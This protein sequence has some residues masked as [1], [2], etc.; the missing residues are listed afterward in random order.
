MGEC[1][2]NSLHGPSLLLRTRDPS[3]SLRMTEQDLLAD[4]FGPGFQTLFYLRHELVGYCAV[5]EAVVVA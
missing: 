1:R 3:A 2:E 4:F 5:D